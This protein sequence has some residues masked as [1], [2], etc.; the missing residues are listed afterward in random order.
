VGRLA[1]LLTIGSKHRPSCLTRIVRQG[2]SWT[3]DVLRGTIQ[4]PKEPA[5]FKKKTHSLICERLSDD[6]RADIGRVFEAYVARAPSGPATV[7]VQCVAA[8]RS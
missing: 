3:D 5:K 1:T 6:P 7:L 8:R 4:G 2:I